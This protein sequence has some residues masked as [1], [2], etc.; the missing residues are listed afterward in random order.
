MTP[1]F[2]DRHEEPIPHPR[3]NPGNLDGQWGVVVFAASPVA[4]NPQR[5][6][7]SRRTTVKLL[8][9]EFAL[10]GTISGG[11]QY[12]PQPSPCKVLRLV[13]R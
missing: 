3:N 9:L 11:R 8:C 7:L 2:D 4:Q 13:V 12:V 5:S 10:A 1:L 6:S